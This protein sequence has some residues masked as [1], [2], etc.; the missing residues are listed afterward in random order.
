M[1]EKNYM[2]LTSQQNHSTALFCMGDIHFR[3]EYTQ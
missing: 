2:T 1:K 3:G